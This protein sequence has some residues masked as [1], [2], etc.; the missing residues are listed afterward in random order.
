MLKNI[1]LDVLLVFKNFIFWLKIKFFSW[2]LWFFLWIIFSI[3][4]II[5]TLFYTYKTNFD[6]SN[7]SFFTLDLE[8]ITDP[9]LFFLIIL[10][11]ILFSLWFFYNYIFLSKFYLNFFEKRKKFEF[12]IIKN[13][14]SFSDL[15]KFL[16]ISVFF[17][18]FSTII[19][20]LIF[21][22]YTFLASD[23][24]MKKSLSYFIATSKIDTNIALTWF[25]SLFLVFI[26]I[27]L[28][29]RFSFSYFFIFEKENN[30]F[31][32]IKKSIKNTASFKKF[33]IFLSCLL[34]AFSPFFWAK[35]I[36]LNSIWNLEKEKTNISYYLYLKQ[37]KKEQEN[38]KNNF[39]ILD[40]K[41]F[42]SN[43]NDLKSRL[44]TIIFSIYFINI[45]EFLF[46][47]WSF[48]LIYTSIYR[49]LIYKK[50]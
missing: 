23:E 41:Y 47:F 48:T 28:I 11:S 21:S 39:E 13:F 15:K 8:K 25:F 33:I 1:F 34:I 26:I 42:W 20:F 35:Y 37:N 43:E 6:I 4:S 3:P 29:Y 30:F 5:L 12:K 7:F 27:Y 14:F 36:I 40:L 44:Q 38:H 45:I 32:S 31:K 19:S 46:I 24:E 10:N 17:I 50:W 49:N 18:I 9:I 2:I 22:I 16:W